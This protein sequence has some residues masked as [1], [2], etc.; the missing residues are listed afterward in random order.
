[1]RSL[2]S[3]LGSL[4]GALALAGC[5]QDV[6]HPTAA[7][8]CDPKVMRCTGGPLQ[9]GGGDGPSGGSGSG[10]NEVATLDGRVLGFTDDFFEQGATF[11]GRAEVSADGANGSRV[12]ADYDGTSFRLVDVLK[13]SVNW[14]LTEPAA[15]SGFLPT[16]IAADTRTSTAD[17]LLVPVA[18]AAQI[19]AILQTLGTTPASSRAQVVMRVV[20]QQGRS[21]R[22]VTAELN[23]ELVAYRTAGAW[24]GNE[25]GTD[26]SGLLLI[27]NAAAGTVLARSSVRLGGAVSATVNVELRAG[28]TTIV[29]AVVTPK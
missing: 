16:V 21:V 12:R 4:L 27:G 14:F 18:P 1:M 28:A 15:S 26:D 24:L 8:A 9:T 23:A 19:E 10:G 22:G 3:L 25:V 6:D 17:E 29:N 20:D 5:G 13:T 2:L 7:A 11:S